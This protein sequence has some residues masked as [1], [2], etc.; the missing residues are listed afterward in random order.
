MAASG[1]VVINLPKNKEVVRRP[2]AVAGFNSGN[3]ASRRRWR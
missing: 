2:N 1:Q 3:T